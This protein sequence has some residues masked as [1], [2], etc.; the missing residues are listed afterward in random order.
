MLLVGARLCEVVPRCGCLCL[1]ERLAGLE[2][3]FDVDLPLTGQPVD[4]PDGDRR[5]AQSLHLV[6][7]VALPFA[8]E[9]LRDLVARGGELVQRQRVEVVELLLEAHAASLVS[10]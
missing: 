5:L 7:E 4:E 2:E 10:F 3:P 9:P 1:R 6:G 8:S